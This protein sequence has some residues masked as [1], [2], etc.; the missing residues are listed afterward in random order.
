MWGYWD[1][2]DLLANDVSGAMVLLGWLGTVWGEYWDHWYSGVP[3]AVVVHPLS[4]EHWCP[5]SSV[6]LLEE[7]EAPLE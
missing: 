2:W 5:G 3:M 6:G 7:P 4:G 1:D